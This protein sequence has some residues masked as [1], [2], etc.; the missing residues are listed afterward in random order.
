M[1]VYFENTYGDWRLIGECKEE[2]EVM[3]IIKKFLQNHHFKSHYT[4]YWD[5]DGW[6]HYDV[7]SH[8]EFFHWQTSLEAKVPVIKE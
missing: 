8:T 6:R 5:S 3:T 4:R 7:G 1:K 2:K